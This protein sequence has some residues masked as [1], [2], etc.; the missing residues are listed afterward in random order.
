MRKL[1]LGICFSLLN[2]IVLSQVISGKVVDA[3]TGSPIPSVTVEL[4]N[5]HSV[6]TN[7][8]GLFIFSKLKSGNYQL[9]L[10]SI[11]YKSFEIFASTKET[12]LVLKMDQWKLFM[13]PIEVKAVRAGDKAPFA[14]TTLTKKEIEKLNLG[15][16]LPFI[17]NQTPSVVINADAGNGV[18]YTGIRIR[19]TDAT[20]INMT[21][22]GIPYNDAESQGLFF[23][24]L[25]D[26]ASSVNNI[27]IQRGVGTS[28][29]GT[30]AFGATINFSTNEVNTI[31]YAEIN[32]SYGSFNTWKN[33]FKVGSGLLS[34]HFTI[35]ARLSNISSDGYVDR[36][37]SKLS[38]FYLSG[39][40]LNEKTSIRLNI[41]SGKEK[42]YQSWYGIT[43]ADLMNNRSF[44][45]AGTERPG[46][47]YD[48]ETD[49]YKQ[50]HYQLFMNHQ[51]NKNIAVQTALYLTKGKGYYEQ[52]KAA[53]EFSKYGLNDMII[54]TDTISK[55]DLI[56]QLWLDNN[57]FGQVF[58][59]QYKKNKNQL[60]IGGGWS[61]YNGNHFGEIIWAAAGVP[62][63][64][65]WYNHDAYKTDFNAYAKCQ[66]SLSP[67]IS[68]FADLQYR[69][70]FYNIDG[71]RDNPTIKIKENYSFLNPKLGVNYSIQNYQLF[72]SYSLGQK[73][74]N[75]D[76]FEA[77]T[78]QLPKSEKL[79]DIE[80]GVEKKTLHYNWG[81]TFYYMR[82]KN[83]LVLTGKVNDVGAYTRSNIPVSYR[84]GLEIQGKAVA[85]NWL[86]LAGTFTISRNEVK[87]FVEFYD[88]YDNGGQKKINHGTT[89]IAYSPT[90]VAGVTVNFIPVRNL[91]I[92]LPGKYVSRQYLDNTSNKAR[93]LKEF[94][95]QD[96]R[97]GYT[98]YKSLFKE[99][100][101]VLQLIN[102]FDK[103]YE[104]NGYTFT[105]QYGGVIT[106]E[107]YYFP[108][109]G[110]NFMIALQVRL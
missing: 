56:R 16:D 25:P 96:L 11:G 104:P 80:L 70:I 58:S 85:T 93:S 30:G 46:A 88:D 41:F 102:V 35:D 74:P 40:F 26:I 78:D 73:E 103:R 75:R 76:D 27:Q 95:V 108:M 72:L 106:T 92:S 45:S 79:H 14:K 22:N 99:T 53:Q 86:N 98:L 47:P 8:S 19:G 109:A 66:F 84:L 63:R 101:F 39:A 54:A 37:S 82:Y 71:F 97:I 24:N 89:S 52:Y 5:Q 32:N 20:R 12:P 3:S 77:G 42:T 43:E 90:V 110:R 83:Q 2:Q 33:T 18:G 57:F 60:T 1:L 68:L 6:I 59:L 15:Q 50:D 36:A 94:Y 62:D 81:A 7:E 49:N 17:L 61:R 107:N 48:N 31:P 4:D 29:N 55:T 100:T 34:D 64:Y 38:S 91:E 105:Y 28:S 21:I 65:K 51:L 10:S 69:R 87:N 13:Q 23:V 67:G 44:N 9:R